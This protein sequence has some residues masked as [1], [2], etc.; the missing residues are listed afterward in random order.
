M[1]NSPVTYHFT[2]T[3]PLEQ[4]ESLEQLFFFNPKQADYLAEI[5]EAVLQFGSPFIEQTQNGIRLSL[6]KF[7]EA[8]CLF[9]A[10]QESTSL[11]GTAIYTLNDDQELEILHMATASNIFYDNPSSE[12]TYALFLEVLRIARRI[13][14]VNR[15]RLPYGRGRVILKEISKPKYNL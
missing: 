6:P 3:L 9:V 2:S 15:V 4:R 14:G 5:N 7:P 11:L 8:Q 1:S 13:K 12:I 10:Y